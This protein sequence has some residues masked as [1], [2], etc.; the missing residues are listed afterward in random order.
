MQLAAK[1]E[2]VAFQHQLEGLRLRKSALKGGLRPSLGMFGRYIYA[3]PGLDKVGNE[4]MN[5]W[6]LGVNLNWNLWDWGKK[7]AQI[8]QV[9]QSLNEMELG[10]QKLQHALQADVQRTYLNCA[11]VKQQLSITTKM[12][13][14]AEENFRIVSNRYEQG[15]EINSA[16]LDAQSDLTRSQLQQIQRK[17]DLQIALADYQRALAT[18]S[19]E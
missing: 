18:G 16:F 12:L 3:K 7:S 4:W 6:I 5:Y 8:Q 10:Y 13:K 9:Q 2:T 15:L 17:I 14:Q 19:A 1:P 11:D